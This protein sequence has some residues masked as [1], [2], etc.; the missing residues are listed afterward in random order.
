MWLW[1]LSGS[2]ASDFL[3]GLAT[4]SVQLMVELVKGDVVS[5][6]KGG[7]AFAD[8]GCFGFSLVGV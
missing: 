3:A 4:R 2:L 1:S 5:A 6:L 8:G 7:A